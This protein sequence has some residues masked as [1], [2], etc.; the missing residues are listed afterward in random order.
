MVVCLVLLV[1]V[2]GYE[3]HVHL[4]HLYSEVIGVDLFGAVLP[5][6]LSLV[7]AFR[8]RGFRGSNGTYPFRGRRFWVPASLGA[9]VLT[10]VFGYLQASSK[11]LS[12]TSLQA[13]VAVPVCG[14]FGV[15][16]V[17]RSNREFPASITSLEVYALGV[18]GALASDMVLSLGGWTQLRGGSLIWGGNGFHDLVLWLGLYMALPAFAYQ[19]LS[20]V[21]IGA[22][23]SLE[24]RTTRPG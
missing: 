11:S 4:F 1:V 21:L 12:L 2:P 15:A 10:V 19:K 5:A 18:V 9:S 17:L 16:Y 6:V 13:T 24:K 22:L 3:A 20:P 14:I 23:S 7:L 8:F